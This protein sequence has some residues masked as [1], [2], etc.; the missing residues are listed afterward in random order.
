MKFIFN[1]DKLISFVMPT[2]LIGLRP[3]MDIITKMAVL[4]EQFRLKLF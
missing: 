2:V 1:I 4:Y 3:N